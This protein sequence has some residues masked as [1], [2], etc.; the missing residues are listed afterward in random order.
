MKHAIVIPNLNGGGA[1]RV[2][3]TMAR[4]LIKIG[5]QVDILVFEKSIR[6]YPCSDLN[7][8]YCPIKPYNQPIK[9]NILKFISKLIHI[10]RNVKRFNNIIS[11]YQY[12]CVSAHMYDAHYYCIKAA[13]TNLFCYIHSTTSVRYR[14]SY[15]RVRTR[16]SFWL[17]QGSIYKLYAKQKLIA[18]SK[19]VEQDF[20]QHK[21]AYKSLQTIYNPLDIADIQQLG[22]AFTVDE[23]DYIVFVGR[24]HKLK[25][26]DILLAAYKQSGIST[27]LLLIGKG[28]LESY[29]KQLIL[30]YKLQHKVILKG[31]N[32][33]PYPYMK[34]AK[35][36][37][38]SS[39]VEGFGLVLVESLILG[40][41][42]VS[43]NCPSGP[44]EILVG[45]LEQFLSPV[46]DITALAHNICKV[47]D[48]P[49]VIT[50]DYYQRFSSEVQVQK[51]LD[52]CRDGIKE[53][54]K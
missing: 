37:V 43:T 47:I 32:S 1:E 33:N 13:I 21:Y 25:C 28:S 27:K 29:I 22:N 54:D 15:S 6:D 14:E 52:L 10:R 26:F 8:I 49:P 45:E 40:T 17:L 16:F 46:G 50:E 30:E 42:V 3:L 11:Q 24:F 19:G 31:F 20:K 41:P 7:I 48:Q 53:T 39:D 9:Y 12:D 44:S 18:V 51:Y 34:N 4:Q 2:V 23:Q 35:A 36:L 5:H 38:M